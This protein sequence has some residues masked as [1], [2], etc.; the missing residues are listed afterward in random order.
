MTIQLERMGHVFYLDKGR[1]I[2][3]Y[4]DTS[5]PAVPFLKPL[6]A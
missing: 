3:L 4:H 6:E 1:A 2:E 5:V